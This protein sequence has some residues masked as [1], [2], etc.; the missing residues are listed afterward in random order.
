MTTSDENPPREPSGTR[1]S[2]VLITETYEAN[3]RVYGAKKL[4]VALNSPSHQSP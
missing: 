3:Y 1:S 4:W 2:E